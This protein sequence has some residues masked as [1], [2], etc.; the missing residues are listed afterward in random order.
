MEGVLADSLE[1]ALQKDNGGRGCTM[2]GA[3]CTMEGAICTIQGVIILY[4][5]R[6]ALWEREICTIG[7]H[8]LLEKGLWREH[9][10]QRDLYTRGSISYKRGHQRTLEHYI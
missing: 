7:E 5:G 9:F 8:Y 10:I 2:E 1:G 4:R 3:I 6:P